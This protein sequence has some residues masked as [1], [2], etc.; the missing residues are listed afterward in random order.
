MEIKERSLI[1]RYIDNSLSGVELKEFMDKLESDEHFRK[2]VSFH[3]LLFES[4]Q[5]AEDSRIEKEII[6]KLGYRKPF[7]PF[8]LKLIIT[9]LL[10]T[11]SGIILWQYIGKSTLQNRRRIFGFELFRKANQ[12]LNSENLNSKSIPIVKEKTISRKESEDVADPKEEEISKVKTD[13][14]SDT[15]GDTEQMNDE[16]LVF[17]KDQMLVSHTIKISEIKS[18]VNRKPVENSMAQSTANK[19][20]PAAGLVNPT[21]SNGIEMEVEFWLS[22]INYRGYK[23]SSNKLILFGI[24]EPDAIKLYNFEN[25]LLMKYGQDFYRLNQ[26]DEFLS[27]SIIKN[28]EL[29]SVLK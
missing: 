22:P 14:A 16:N 11:T 1:D 21:S 10:V 12:N 6:S 17:K 18:E 19:L 3:N 13:Q 4:I 15:T 26:T 23:M 29:P 24:E 9:F 25:R 27:F 8:G 7:I 5:I 28:T 2:M 20:N